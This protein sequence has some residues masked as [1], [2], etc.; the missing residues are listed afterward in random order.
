MTKVHR[1]QGLIAYDNDVNI[2]RRVAG[3]DEVYPV[4]RPRTVLYAALMALVGLVM[5]HGLNHRS[6]T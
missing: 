5:L 3:K 6:F 1:P 4:I 2:A